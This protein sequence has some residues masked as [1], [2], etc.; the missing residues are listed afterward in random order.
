MQVL[1]TL[2]LFKECNS[3]GSMDETAIYDFSSVSKFNR[4]P[5]P[6]TTGYLHNSKKYN[7]IYQ[8]RLEYIFIYLSNW[9]TI[10]Q[11]EPGISGTFLR[12]DTED[13]GLMTAQNFDDAFK[14]YRQ[15]SCFSRSIFKFFFIFYSF[16][17]AHLA[18]WAF[19][20][21]KRPSV[22]CRPLAFHI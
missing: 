2:S 21:D 11:T 6:L 12:Y 5:E 17:L 8:L 20:M 19:V 15:N 16:C 13:P 10:W 3:R 22:V 9:G 18:R 7:C 14:I 4:N 1:F